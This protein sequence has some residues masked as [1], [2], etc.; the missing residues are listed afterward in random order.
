MKR[1]QRINL[2]AGIMQ[3]LLKNDN[4]NGQAWT[5]GGKFVVSSRYA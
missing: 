3:N 4:S 1:V 5:L 2:L